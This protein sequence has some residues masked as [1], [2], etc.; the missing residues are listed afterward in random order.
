MKIKRRLKLI[1][2]STLT[3][4]YLTGVLT[5]VL[6]HWFQTDHGFGPESSPFKIWWL[7]IHS[8]ISLWFLVLF[9]FLFHS[10]VIPA[11]KRRK[12]RLSGGLLTGT[13]IFLALTVPGLFYLTNES[14][15]SSVALVHTY[16]G[17]VLLFIF[18]FH[19]FAKR[20]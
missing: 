13:L 11:W 19:Y 1:L 6:G 10:H 16:V 5:W 14:L 17:L 18:L 7:Q 20:N 8:I 15:K 12:R 2:P 9:G 4:M 3:L